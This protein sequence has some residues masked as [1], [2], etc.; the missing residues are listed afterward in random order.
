MIDPVAAPVRQ[1]GHQTR[2]ERSHATHNS[3]QAGTESRRTA[4]INNCAA[5]RDCL[6][7]SFF[8]AENQNSCS[9]AEPQ[10]CRSIRLVL[11]S[12]SPTSPRYRA[13][14]GR[15]ANRKGHGGASVGWSST[16][17]AQFGRRYEPSNA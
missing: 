13:G 4:R 17:S 12:L 3:I 1:R 14:S 7:S 11:W 10:H 8:V 9:H 2:R 15:I 5:K 6:T 16:T